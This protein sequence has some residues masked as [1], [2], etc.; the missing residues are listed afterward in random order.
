MDMGRFL[1]GT[2]VRTGRPIKELARTHE[3]SPSWLFKL[4]RR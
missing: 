3:V 2:Q 1:I 4:L